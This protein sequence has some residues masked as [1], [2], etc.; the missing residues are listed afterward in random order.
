M[1]VWLVICG[2]TAVTLLASLRLLALWRQTRALPELL[3]AVLMVGVGVLGVGGGFMVNQ[4]FEASP[5]LEAL[6]FIPQLGVVT[7]LSALGGF[8]CVV[9]HRE[10]RPALLAIGLHVAALLA[11][12]AYAVTQGSIDAMGRGRLAPLTQLLYVTPMYWNAFDALR[13]WR[14]MRRREAI[15]LAD[16]LLTN[17]FLLW[18]IGTGTAGTGILVGAI[19][20]VFLQIDIRSGS[21][22]FASYAVHGVLA[23]IAFWLAFKPPRFYVRWIEGMSPAA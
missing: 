10:S 6:R 9:Y 11:L 21:F 1:V 5:Y 13:Y 4:L 12:T 3:I 8:T 19:A 18:A 17:R 2:F 15:G 7:G 16:P 14:A 23:A 22:V 20:S